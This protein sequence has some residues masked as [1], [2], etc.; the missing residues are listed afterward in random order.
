MGLVSSPHVR[1]LWCAFLLSFLSATLSVLSLQPRHFGA[2]C[3]YVATS[4]FQLVAFIILGVHQSLISFFE[5]FQQGVVF[6]SPGAARPCEFFWFSSPSMRRGTKGFE[7]LGVR[8]QLCRHSY[9]AMGSMYKFWFCLLL[10][11]HG[12]RIGEP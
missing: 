3:R 2:T 5:W 4:L 7:Q 10:L 8:S 6:L 12:V 11:G 9:C 1:D